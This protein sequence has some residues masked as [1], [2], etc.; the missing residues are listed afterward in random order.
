MKLQLAAART[1]VD[2]M[3]QGIRIFWRQ[4]IALTGLFFMLLGL[5]TLIS[6]VPVIGGVLALVL[7]PT[8]SLGL[9]VGTREALQG[10]FPRPKLLLAGLLGTAVVRRQMLWLGAGYALGFLGVL[11]LSMWADGGEFARLYLLG[12]KLDTHTV[13]LP[14]F[15]TAVWTALLLYMP[16]SALFWHAP[17]LVFWH[18]VPAVKS[19]FFSMAAC[20][21]N[22]KAM[23]LYMLCWTALYAAAGLALMIAGGL[24]GGMEIVGMA[25]VPTMLMFTAM[26]FCSAYFTYRDSF[27]TSERLG[28]DPN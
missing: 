4:P 27:E 5:M 18:G 16:L 9:M 2:W 19:V 26:F 14:G 17:A 8:G 24:L 11:V 6:I 15:Q 12:G 23:T 10:R 25:L 3:R 20:L 7:F 22:W 21:A 13:E 1:G 28:P